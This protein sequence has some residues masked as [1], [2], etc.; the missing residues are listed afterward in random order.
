MTQV[1]QKHIVMLAA[2][3]RARRED[4]QQS[5]LEQ[6]RALDARG[7]SRLVVNLVELPPD[8]L[9]YRPS[10]ELAKADELPA[11][12]VIIEL[13][14]HDAAKIAETLARRVDVSRAHRFAVDERIEKDEQ[15]FTVGER[16]PGIKY[17]GR[18]MFHADLPDSA[19]MRSWNLHVGLALR[20][21]AGASKYVRN[22]VIARHGENVPPTRAVT[23]L[24]FRSHQDMIEKFF[25]GEHGKQE[26]LHDLAHFVAEGHRFYCSEYVVRR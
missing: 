18:L 11:Y 5:L 10:G 22:F 4:F 23:E 6:A 15:A 26:V 20:V 21:H 24:H 8:D 14:G 7:L 19:V 3:D 2:A 25:D 17:M 1:T 13:V 16:S 12:D 9:P